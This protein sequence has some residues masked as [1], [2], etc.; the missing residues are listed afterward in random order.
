MISIPFSCRASLSQRFRRVD[1]EVFKIAFVKLHTLKLAPE[2]AAHQ[3]EIFFRV[4][5]EKNPFDVF[6]L[7]QRSTERAKF[8]FF[9]E[10]GERRVLGNEPR[11]RTFGFFTF[12]KLSTPHPPSPAPARPTPATNAHLTPTLSPFASEANAEREKIRVICG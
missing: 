6:P 2:R 11:L 1:A 10:H 12:A 4:R 8:L 3:T 5:D 9:D 7:R